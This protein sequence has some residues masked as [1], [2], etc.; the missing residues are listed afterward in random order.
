MPKNLRKKL[1]TNYV[2]SDFCLNEVYFC[3]VLCLRIVENVIS[4]IKSTWMFIDHR[5]IDPNWRIY[6]LAHR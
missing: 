2:I 3:L 5:E 4:S 1:K 6:L